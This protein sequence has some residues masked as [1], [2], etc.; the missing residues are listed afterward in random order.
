MTEK[1]ELFKEIH[2]L[3]KELKEKV[4]K[5]KSDIEQFVNWVKKE[6]KDY[7][8]GMSIISKELSI[9]EKE[10]DK[11]SDKV[12]I[13]IL[14]DERKSKN[15]A[16]LK[17]EAIKKVIEK[18]E[19]LEIKPEIQLLAELWQECYDGNYE[20][21]KIFTLGAI[22]HDSGMFSA[23]R[24][25]E[26]HKLMVLEKFER[27]IVSYVLAGSLVR[28]EATPTSDVD[29]FVVIDDT[30]VKR[31]TRAELKDKL[32]AIILESAF[33]AGEKTGIRNKLNVQV[34]ILTE[35]WDSLR[36]A[37]PIIYTFLRDGVPLYDRGIF[38][39]W[40]QL[41]RMGMIQPSPEA[42][43][44]LMETGD[45][46][47]ETVKNKIKDVV[48]EDLY[49][50]IL[51]PSQAALMKYGVAPPAPKETPTLMR[52]LFIEKE[53]LLE[54]KYVKML[55]D[56]IKIR[57]DVEHG[58]KKDVS[59][60]DLKKGLKN[61]E[62]FMKRIK[63]LFREI[64][65]RKDKEFIIKIYDDAISVIREALKM[66]NIE[67]VE[68]NEIY[69]AFNEHLIKTGKLPNN[70]LRDLKSIIEGYNNFEKG[71]LNKLDMTKIR[72]IATN[73]IKTIIEFVQREA[74]RKFEQYK[75]RLELGDGSIL[76]LIPFEDK[77]FLVNNKDKIAYVLDDEFN[78]IGEVSI[79]EIVKMKENGKLR[80]IHLTKQHIEKLEALVGPIKILL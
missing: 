40:K 4:E 20:I 24:I 7:L 15:P 63:Q 44:R 34:Y 14:L 30:D 45:K 62:E 57:K 51:T 55:E 76:E 67:K 47:L 23:L 65:E 21:L 6:F 66:V 60:D 3:P 50:A 79:D 22:L 68:E 33:I 69:D 59:V 19:K 2:I 54:E 10:E 48:T 64:E 8:L 42:V 72:K 12:H 27:Y 31:M 28:G 75:I 9:L 38:M 16:E 29:V 18:T 32:R 71:E 52:E 56:A 74:F 39:P 13:Y 43:E 49:Y 77:I 11:N 61:A 35:F 53:N 70:L 25:A 41:L 37:N 58:F 17:I 1:Q 36:Q 73:F 5:H 26:I 78:K 46:I 80:K